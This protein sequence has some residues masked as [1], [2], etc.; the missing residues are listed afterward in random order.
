M[1]TKK[2]TTTKN[3]ADSQYKW[4][5]TTFHGRDGSSKIFV[6]LKLNP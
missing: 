4:S 3:K 2:K 1:I 5:R 6:S